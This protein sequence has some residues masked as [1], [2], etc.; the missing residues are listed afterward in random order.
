MTE[1]WSKIAS[2]YDGPR[3]VGGSLQV[4]AGRL[5][6]RAHAIDRALK[7]REID[8]P[9]DAISRLTLTDR[10]LLAPRRHVLVETYD[11]VRA[12]FLVNGAKKVI[13]RLSRDVSEATGTAVEVVGLD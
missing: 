12:R 4:G 2:L 13:H 3:A 7:G 5:R 6:F 8:V 9:L 10:S 1:E 11:G